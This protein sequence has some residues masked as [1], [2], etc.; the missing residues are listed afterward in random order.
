MAEIKSQVYQTWLKDFCQ[1]SPVETFA[2]S[3]DGRNSNPIGLAVASDIFDSLKTLQSEFES[4]LVFDSGLNPAEDDL[5]EIR[6]TIEDYP[7][8]PA[9]LENLKDKSRDESL[10]AHLEEFSLEQ[11]AAAKAIRAE[12]NREKQ[13]DQARAAM[14]SERMIRTRL[15][16]AKAAFANWLLLRKDIKSSADFDR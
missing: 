10:L 15:K 8:D 11:P 5:E 3:L 7:Q 14:V 6:I 4:N 1:G 16:N 12:L 9:V 13:K 2:R